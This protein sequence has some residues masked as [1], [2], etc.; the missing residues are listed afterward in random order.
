MMIAANNNHNDNNHLIL[1]G[2]LFR[3]IFFPAQSIAKKWTEWWLE[4]ETKEII[5]SLVSGNGSFCSD[6]S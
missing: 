5:A 4:A 1:S 6:E 2:P 3:M